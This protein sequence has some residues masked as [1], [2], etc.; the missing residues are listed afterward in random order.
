MNVI[1]YF[2]V[3][4]SV[5]EE[6]SLIALTPS[7]RRRAAASGRWARPRTWRR[8]SGRKVSEMFKGHMN[9]IFK[10]LKTR[11]ALLKQMGQFSYLYQQL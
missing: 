2:S 11:E 5:K 6:K 8:R 1:G 10:L 7:S 3:A 9:K 4:K